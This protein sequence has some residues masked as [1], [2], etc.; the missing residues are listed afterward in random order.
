MHVTRNGAPLGQFRRDLIP[1]L[2]KNGTLQP[3]D[4]YYNEAHREWIALSQFRAEQKFAPA[5]AATAPPSELL[6]SPSS[7]SR[8]QAQEEDSG[9][10]EQAEAEDGAGEEVV[11]RRRRRRRHRDESQPRKPRKKRHPAEYS[12]PGWIAALV[13]VGVAVAMYAWAIGLKA[14]LDAS[15]NK[16][17]ELEQNVA[18]LQRHNQIL[19]EMAPPGFVRGVLTAEIVPGRLSVLSGASVAAYKLDDLRTAVLRAANLPTPVNEEEFAQLVTIIQSSLPPPLAVTLTDS[20]GRFE[21]AL[22]EPGKYGIVA[23]ALKQLGGTTERLFWTLEFQS[24]DSPTPILSLSEQ[25]AASVR[26]PQIKIQ[27]AR[28]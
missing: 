19:L 9:S 5:A 27:A 1:E 13:A 28:R 3:T 18:S 2:L 15:L 25:N 10:E 26:Q 4:L 8:E 23:T 7:E 20:S 6:A 14:Q 24:G 17:R 21:L 22:P 12:L 16:L 11:V